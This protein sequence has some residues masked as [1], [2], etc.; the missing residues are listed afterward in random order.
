MCSFTESYSSDIDAIVPVENTTPVHQNDKKKMQ[1]R[2]IRLTWV[3]LLNGAMLSVSDKYDPVSGRTQ[4][5]SELMKLHIQGVWQNAYQFIRQQAHCGGK[6][7]LRWPW[8]PGLEL[9]RYDKSV[10]EGYMIIWCC[11]WVVCSAQDAGD[12]ER[13]QCSHTELSSTASSCHLRWVDG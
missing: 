7:A 8:H 12:Q 11:R 9:L 6:F 5:I 13:L 1:H 3:V 10:Y 2:L 4:E